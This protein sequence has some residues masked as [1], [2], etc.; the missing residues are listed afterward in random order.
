M[1]GWDA[2]GCY[3]IVGLSSEEYHSNWGLRTAVIVLPLLVT[4]ISFLESIGDSTDAIYG[5]FQNMKHIY[6]TVTKCNPE[7]RLQRGLICFESD[8]SQ[9]KNNSLEAFEHGREHKHNK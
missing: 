6:S 3:G 9:A 8:Y 2:M 1:A 4:L 5:N 7:Q